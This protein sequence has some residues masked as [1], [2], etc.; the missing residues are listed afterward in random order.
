MRGDRLAYFS[1]AVFSGLND[2]LCHFLIRSAIFD[3]ID[4]TSIAHYLGGKP[5]EEIDALL[6][7]LVRQ[8]L[9]IQ[10]LFDAHIGRGYRYN[11]LFRDFLL[12]KFRKTIAAGEQQTLLMRA[13]DLA[14]NESDFESA[15]HFFLQA[16]RYGKAAAGIKK[17]AMGLCAQGRFADL[18]GWIGVLPEAM[19]QEDTWLTFYRLMGQRIR[20]G[21]KNIPAFSKAFD[22]FTAED[23]QRGQLLAMSYLIEAAIFIGHPAAE[24][25]GWLETAWTL[26]ERVSGNRYYPFAKATL[27]MQVAFGY[28]TGAGDLQKG[29][30]ACRNAMLLASTLQDDI[31]TVNATIVHV[32]GLTLSG[33]FVVAEKSLAGIRHL[34]VATY[35]E[36]RALRNIVRMQLALSQGDL[37]HAQHLHDANQED[38]DR[39]G[40]L[41]FYPIH[42]DL[43]GLLQIHQRRFEELGRTANH[44]MDVATLAANPF[45]SGLA[46]RLRALNAYHQGRFDRARAWTQQ[47]IDVITQSLGEE[48]VHLYRCRLI[49]GMV[50][51]HLNDLSTAR[52]ALET[53]CDFFE[54]VSSHLSLVETRLGLS[55]VLAAM[56]DRSAAEHARASALGLAAAKGY[57][58]FS[59]LSAGDIAAAC[60]PSIQHGD[61]E[62]ARVARRVVDHL[63]AERPAGTSHG[64]SP[65]TSPDHPVDAQIPAY[66]LDIRTLGRFEVRK[67][68]RTISDAQW[69]GLRQ[70]LLLKAIV[71]NGSRE[72]PK[73]IIMDALW[74]DSSYDAALKRFK[75]TLH[76]LRKIL[77][78][79]VDSRSG[80]SCI[81]L[82][83][84]RISLDMGCCRVDVNDF[85][86]ACDQVRQLR[87]DDDDQLRLAACRAAID[88]YQ[89]DFLPEEPYLGWTETKRALLKDHF[90]SV[91]MEAAGI[92]EQGG[93]TIHAIGYCETVIQTDPLA[94]QAYQQLMRLNMRQGQRSAAL[95]VYRALVNVLAAELDTVPDRETN[96]LYQEI[97]SSS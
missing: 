54:R 1:E 33:E 8:N 74:P 64:S 11:Q 92:L 30:S 66:Y 16:Q 58:A 4:P 86:A 55:L 7:T 52:Q 22:R 61:R 48:S 71:V 47:A 89:G 68:G 51:Y 25:K 23:D 28:I 44:L 29:L 81:L 93:E 39:F 10:P 73:D 75:I 78:P 60:A 13:A 42:V 83:D 59:I 82:K 97:V 88:L 31:L 49:L 2:A 3:T 62:T 91:L 40:L 36:Y 18:A 50:A 87:N 19:V 9:F 20:G 43:S 14:W 67:S 79:D 94:E 84:N 56:H 72:I 35:P 45:Y 65:G 76:R 80:N 77:E 70:K 24:L 26:L 38:I 34:V 17:I 63:G 96:R 90:L 32:F 37:E 21:R 95:K 46:Y 69:A 57:E 27:W 41:F 6:N 15:I 53:A 12:A 5:V 85:L